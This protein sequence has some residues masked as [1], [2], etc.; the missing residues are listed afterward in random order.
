LNVRG[1]LISEAGWAE[2][3]FFNRLQFLK[4]NDDFLPQAKRSVDG[5]IKRSDLDAHFFP[6]GILGASSS[7]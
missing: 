6:K 2:L 5:F 7:R 1:C 3:K 4:T